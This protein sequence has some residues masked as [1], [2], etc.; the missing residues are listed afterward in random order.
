[1]E[2]TIAGCA[3]ITTFAAVDR[4]VLIAAAESSGRAMPVIGAA[5]VFLG[6]TAQRAAI[7]T[8]GTGA[9][10]CAA[11]VGACHAGAVITAFAVAAAVGAASLGDLERAISKSWQEILGFASGSSPSH[12][13]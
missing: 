7:L 4:A 13:L 9:A 3:T 5:G 12:R 10:G 1:M 8:A 11:C 2:A 6:F